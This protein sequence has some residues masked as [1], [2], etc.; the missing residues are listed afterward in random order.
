MSSKSSNHSNRFLLEL[1]R[2]LRSCRLCHLR[3]LA[4]LNHSARDT[5]CAGK[6]KPSSIKRRMIA[7]LTSLMVFSFWLS[8]ELPV[9][10]ERCEPSRLRGCASPR[11]GTALR[12]GETEIPSHATQKSKPCQ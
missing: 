7:L 10:E 8:V 6:V 4:L 2:V 11:A 5:F 12:R 1:E 9:F 3:L